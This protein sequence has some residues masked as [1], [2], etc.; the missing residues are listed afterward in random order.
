MLALMIK[1]QKIDQKTYIGTQPNKPHS[2]ILSHTYT[3]E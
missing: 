2:F 3:I 1:S